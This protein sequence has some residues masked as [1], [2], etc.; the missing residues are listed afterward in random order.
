MCASVCMCV[1]NTGVCM[2]MKVQEPHWISFR[3]HFPSL[4][5]VFEIGFLTEPE[6]RLASQWISGIC[7]SPHPSPQQCVYWIILVLYFVPWVGG[8]VYTC[9]FVA[10][11][12]VPYLL[13]IPYCF[14]A[15]SQWT[16]SSLIWLGWIA[17]NLQGSAC[18]FPRN[19]TTDGA[20]FILFCFSESGSCVA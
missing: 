3:D 1:H 9:S 19:G 5:L 18:L 6:A 10:D 12:W 7:L 17:N 8:G 15:V 13:P 11:I 20:S 4:I 2:D 14:E 16:C